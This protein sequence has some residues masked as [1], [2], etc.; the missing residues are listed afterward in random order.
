M[1][2][3]RRD[4]P[5]RWK[6]TGVSPT[7]SLAYWLESCHAMAKGGRNPGPPQE[8]S[9][10]RRWRWETGEIWQLEF[11]GQSIRKERDSQRTLETCRDPRLGIQQNSNQYMHMKKLLRH[12]EKNNL[13]WLEEIIAGTYTGPEIVPVLT[14]QTRSLIIHETLDKALRKVLPQ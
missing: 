12:E 3:W 8:T 9:W 5:E 4:I 7:V 2:Q 1:K 6:T 14:R 11:T 13:N 10:L